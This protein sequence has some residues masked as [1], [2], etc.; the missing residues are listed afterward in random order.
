MKT[1]FLE[2]ASIDNIMYKTEKSFQDFVN[3][4]LGLA[5]EYGKIIILFTHRISKD[6]YAITPERLEYVLIKCQEYGLPFYRYK[7]FQ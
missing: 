3:S 1:G 4:A 6:D 7:D 2:S 5:K